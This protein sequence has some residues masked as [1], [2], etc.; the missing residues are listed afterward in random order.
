MRYDVASPE[1]Q[2]LQETANTLVSRAM[3]YGL[4]TLT[5]DEQTYYLVWIAEGE[6]GNGG[7][8]AVCYN[9]TGNYLRGMP[10]AFNTLG[11]P[12]K[13]ALFVR[14]ID[15]FGAESPSEI[16]DTRLT[17]H[18]ALP[19]RALSEINSLDGAY[20]AAEDVTAALYVLAQKIRQS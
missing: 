10:N 12:Q 19:E 3:K 7:M 5:P 9:S 8:H 18:N 14:L 15:A 17:Q 20:F 2:F 16:H 1:W 6:V 13:A 4:S 11:A